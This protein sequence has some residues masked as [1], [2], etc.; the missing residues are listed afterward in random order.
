MSGGE[1]CVVTTLFDQ[2][3]GRAGDTKKK[4][5]HFGNH[6][7]DSANTAD[8]L[9]PKSS[10]ELTTMTEI[11]E[12][13]RDRSVTGG[14]KQPALRKT[15]VATPQSRKTKTARALLDVIASPPKTRRPGLVRTLA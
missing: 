9:S 12:R 10:L 4:K 14:T 6:V 13:R 2:R 5:A 15:T 11:R 1:P 8:A 3:S 7:H